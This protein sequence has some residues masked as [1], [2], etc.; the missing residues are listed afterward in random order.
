MNRTSASVQALDHKS[1]SLSLGYRA[2]L[3][4]VSWISRKYLWNVS[5]CSFFDMGFILLKNEKF[6]TLK[7]VKDKVLLCSDN[8]F[9]PWGKWQ[10]WQNGWLINYLNHL[11]SNQRHKSRTICC[12]WGVVTFK[13]YETFLLRNTLACRS[14]YRFYGIQIN[15]MIKNDKLAWLKRSLKHMMNGR[16]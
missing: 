10:M 13:T 16:W 1:S 14:T 7:E 9:E 15:K 8:W 5:K 12:K 3:I 6:I 2:W 4:M 11:A